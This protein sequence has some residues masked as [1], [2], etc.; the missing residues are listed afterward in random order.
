[1]DQITLI[2]PDDTSIRTLV[3]SALKDRARVL[4]LS[5]RQTKARIQ[6]FE[7]TYGLQTTEFLEKFR[8][9]E[10]QHSFD[11]DDWIG[12]SRM[13]TR[14]QEKLTRLQGIQIVD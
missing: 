11:F 9:N 5:I 6:K 1:M 13:L 3:E 14:L 7:E 12:E 8:N 4:E 10:F 2:S